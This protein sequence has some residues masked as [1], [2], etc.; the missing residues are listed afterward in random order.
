MYLSSVIGFALLVTMSTV[1]FDVPKA[2]DK[3]KTTEDKEVRKP[4]PVQIDF[5]PLPGRDNDKT[6]I[7]TL[8]IL[9][10]DGTGITNKGY[11]ISH[12][13]AQ[14]DVQLLVRVSLGKAVDY[15]EVD[16]TT[17]RINS[18]DGKPIAD[19]KIKLEGLPDGRAWSQGRLA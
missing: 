8:S 13:T 1:T 16:A 15:K 12:N 3:P 14:E 6:Y 17:L 18:I 4:G 11:K 2:E 7:L 10:A 9:A 5:G 19:V